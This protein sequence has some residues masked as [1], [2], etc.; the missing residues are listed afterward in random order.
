MMV[1][2]R[3]V[4]LA[5]RRAWVCAVCGVTWPCLRSAAGGSA[6]AIAPSNEPKFHVGDAVVLRQKGGAVP[7]RYEIEYAPSWNN[8]EQEWLYPLRSDM[9][10]EYKRRTALEH[11]LVRVQG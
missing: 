10:T 3:P 7:R 8:S 1:D 9:G 6:Q 11:A 4:A 5:D 2:C